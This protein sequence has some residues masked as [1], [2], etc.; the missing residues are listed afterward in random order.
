MRVFLKSLPL[1]FLIFLCSA[2]YSFSLSWTDKD[3]LGSG[4]PSNVMGE[5][6]LESADIVS[7][8]S[9]NFQNNGIIIISRKGVSEKF[10]LDGNL[11]PNEHNLVELAILSNE[12]NSV[13]N[14]YL[15]IRPHLISSYIRSVGETG[16]YDCFIKIYKFISQENARHNKYSTWNIYLLKKH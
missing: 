7:N 4:C 8:N 12:D 13:I 3:W 6:V 14:Q 10:L 15:K 9:I 11:F 5:W 2:N 16:D 1:F